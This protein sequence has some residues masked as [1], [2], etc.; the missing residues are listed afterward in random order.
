[1]DTLQVSQAVLDWAAGQAGKTLESLAEEIV[2]K[3]IIDRFLAGQLTV[4]QLEKVAATTNIPFGYLFLEEPPTVTKPQIPD[5]RQIPNPAPFGSDFFEVLDDVVKKQDWYL[6]YLNDVGA[7]PLDFVGRYDKNTPAKIIAAD[8]SKTADIT[9]ETRRKA[10]NTDEYY[11]ILAEKF[12]KIGVLVFKSGIVRSNT[13]KSLSVAEFR[14]F[15][16]CNKYAP[17]VFING[18]D[19]EAAWIFTLAHEIAHIWIGESGVSDIPAPTD[20]QSKG[21]IEFLCNKVAAELLTPT[22]EFLNLWNEE[23][24]P[25]IETLSKHFKVS[26]LVIARKALDLGKIGRDKYHSVYAQSQRTATTSGGN[27][28][29]TIPIR[30]SKKLTNALVRSA[31][32]GNVLIRDAA[33]LLNITPD[34]VANIYKKNLRSHA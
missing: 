25:S 12:E 8:I 31:M 15:A 21:S 11:K 26:R 13:R 33:R 10:R 22:E 2:A 28:Y 23:H 3:K 5:M 24:Q 19:A 30:N 32:E 14:G 20:F 34:T 7:E 1:M 9:A 16:I 4:R 17:V 6:D 29:A 18:R 27:P